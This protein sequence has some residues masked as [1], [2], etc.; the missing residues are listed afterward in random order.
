M[1]PVRVNGGAAVAGSV[2]A[3]WTWAGDG[4]LLIASDQGALCCL[5]VRYS[6]T[7]WSSGT[8][9]QCSQSVSVTVYVC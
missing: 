9:T 4:R 6:V 5:H 2:P 3:A 7:G 1:Y 8:Q